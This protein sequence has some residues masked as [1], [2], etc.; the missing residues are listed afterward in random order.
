[1]LHSRHT[2]PR[3]AWSH[4][5]WEDFA[6]APASAT[7]IAILPLHGTGD[8]GLGL[9]L[10]VE[11]AIWEPLIAAAVAGI[12]PAEV[13][14]LPPLRHVLGPY[15]SCCF[16]V[17]PDTAH[18]L[19]LE[20][21]AGVHA[22]GFRKL[23]LLNSS[24]W[25]VEL[26]ATAALDLRASLALHTYV[27]HGSGVG[28]DLHPAGRD[29]ARVQAVA[30]TLLGITPEAPFRDG[31]CA[32]VALRPGY[33]N[34]PLSLPATPGLAGGAIAI[35][36]AARLRGLFGEIAAHRT[37]G[38]S[39]ALAN[40]RRPAEA[41]RAAPAPAAPQRSLTHLTAGQLAALTA[42]GGPANAVAIIATGAIEQHGPHLPVG[43]DTFLG[44]I[45]SSALS[46]QLSPGASVWFA[47]AM[48]LGKSSEHR[49]FPGTLS[50]S[51]RT[52][53]QAFLAQ[54]RQLHAWG[55]RRLAVLN[56]HGGNSAVLTYTLREVQTTLGLR[57]ALLSVPA[58]ADL[59]THERLHGFHAGA[60]ETSLML[61]A[62]P[63]L[64]R[65]E[66]ATS[67]YPARSDDPGSLRPEK[68][69]ATFAWLTSDLSRSGVM[70]DATAASAE[71]GQAWLEAGAKRLAESIVR[72]GG[73]NAPA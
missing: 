51:T 18:A 72:F 25:N 14:V 36:A 52:L 27:I 5:T 24:P 55:F 62:M 69:P 65:R 57:T 30:S 63:D 15:A 45:W 46:A 40:W 17:D 41:F 70:G 50:L 73:S 3:T 23:V 9:P 1:M 48:L 26:A 54:A 56:T 16:G 53:R 2:D 31:D 66:R 29:R 44:D 67:E 7:R 64:V 4:R 34:L 43:V 11:E 37:P 13:C 32:D 12:D 60:W 21:G 58:A 42:S 61:A 68:A 47:P 59:P 10:A 39:P 19:L 71:S 33:W 20:I 28:L 6:T 8:H 38:T 22:A 49:D 35:E